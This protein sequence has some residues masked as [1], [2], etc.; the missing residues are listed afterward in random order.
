[1]GEWNEKVG[2]KKEMVMVMSIKK[3]GRMK[4]EKLDERVE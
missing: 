4:E 2:G 1:M 3:E